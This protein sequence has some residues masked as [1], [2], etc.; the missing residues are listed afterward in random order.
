MDTA[1]RF[2]R[3]SLMLAIFVLI[4]YMTW[5]PIV[6]DIEEIPYLIGMSQCNLGEPW[7]IEMNEELIAQAQKYPEIRL[8]LTDA[9]QDN[10]KQIEDVKWLM[11]LGIDLLIISPNES[12]PLTPIISEVYQKIP[13]IVLDRKVNSDDYTLFIGA[14]NRVIGMRAGE[15]VRPLLGPSGGHVVEI[16]GLPGSKP[17]VERSEGFR[18]GISAQENIRIVGEIT[19][20]WLRDPAE[21]GFYAYLQTHASEKIDVVY[22]HNDPMALGAYR[23]AQKA[24]RTGM[25]FV[26][27]DG[28]IGEEGGI[29]LVKEGILDITFIYPTGGAEAIEYALKIL[30]QQTFPQK[31]IVLG[32]IRIDKSNCDQYLPGET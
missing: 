15:N 20:N 19:A 10:Q 27:I 5:R 7:R 25:I 24:H 9:A 28:L 6:A 26:G 14:N 21:D 16:M 12:E 2:Y 29:N 18:D 11:G 22:S 1:N 30:R 3:V 13:V 23:A 8:V 4:F 17:T 32:N 31:E